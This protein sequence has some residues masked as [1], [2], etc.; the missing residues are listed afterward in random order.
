VIKLQLAKV[1]ADM[2]RGLSKTTAVTVSVAKLH[3]AIGVNVEVVVDG[4]GFSSRVVSS[5]TSEQNSY[6]S[7]IRFSG[8]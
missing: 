5:S 8:C 3:K 1:A 7:G 4:E 6:S 2:V